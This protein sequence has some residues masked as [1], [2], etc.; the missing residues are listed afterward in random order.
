MDPFTATALTYG[1]KGLAAG[2]GTLMQT[3]AAE[4]AARDQAAAIR[5]A[6]A[7]Q[8]KRYNESKEMFSP[9]TEAGKRGVQ[10]YEDKISSFTKPEFDYNQKDFSFDTFSDPGAVY[11]QEQARKALEGQAAKSGMSLSSGLLKGLQTRSQDMASQEYANSYD[12]FMKD[13]VLR[14]GQASDKYGRD[15]GF[16]KDDISNWQNLTGVGLNATGAITGQ[17]QQN[18]AQQAELI[19]KG[20]ANTGNAQMYGAG[21]WSSLLNNL[22][23]NSNKDKEK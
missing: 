18:A 13:S 14:Y 8:E 15:L 22:F 3:K 7:L 4:R 17:G 12:R 2:F 11:R 20:A 23:G 21:A 19:Q 16:L 6:T 9:Y 1:G 10:G 5:E